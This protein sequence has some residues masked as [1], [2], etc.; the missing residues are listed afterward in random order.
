MVHVCVYF[1][2][3]MCAVEFDDDFDE[4]DGF[5]D[6]DEYDNFDWGVQ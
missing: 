6:A 5:D 1:C 3:E 4:L 2:A